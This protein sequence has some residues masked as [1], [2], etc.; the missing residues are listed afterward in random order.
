[1]VSRSHLLTLS[2]RALDQPA[3]GRGRPKDNELAPST[4]DTEDQVRQRAFELWEQGGRPDDYETE[5]VL[6]P[7]EAF[8]SMEPVTVGDSENNPDQGSLRKPRIDDGV[9]RKP[10]RMRTAD[11]RLPAGARSVEVLDRRMEC[12]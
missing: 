12:E 1:M 6:A 11:P 8:P 2:P 3:G 10:S 4:N 9:D 5:L 7:G